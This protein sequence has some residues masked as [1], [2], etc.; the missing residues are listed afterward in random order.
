MARRGPDGAI[1]WKRGSGEREA[2]W[3]QVV[4]DWSGSGL[5]KVAFCRKQGLS[6]SAFHWW[7]GELARRDATK[8]VHSVRPCSAKELGRETKAKPAFVAVRV[9]E[10]ASG[11]SAERE[12]EDG[13]IEGGVEVVLGSGRRVR[14]SSGF[15]TEVLARVV[16]VLEGLPC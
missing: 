9:A 11:G 5:S 2:H 6:P 15:D 14:V 16:G 12:R 4:A 8:S 1:Q 3:R 10:G 7:R 13:G